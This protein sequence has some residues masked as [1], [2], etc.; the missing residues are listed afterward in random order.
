MASSSD[1]RE[2]LDLPRGSPT[3]R[4]PPAKKFKAD[5]KKPDGMQRELYSLLGENT[6]PIA[7]IENKFKDRPNWRQKVTPWV[8]APF[9][10]SNDGDDDLVL[11]HWVR[12]AA[13]DIN[14]EYQFC[15]YNTQIDVP[16][17][18]KEDYDAAFQDSSWSFEE[19]KYLFD[20]C[21][22]Y[23]LRWV[24]IHDR[25]AF[26]RNNSND[27]EPDQDVEMEEANAEDK[28]D[29]NSAEPQTAD[30]DSENEKKDNESQSERE[31]N[32]QS[33][34]S[35]GSAKP[36]ESES[37]T[38][39][40]K[41][42]SDENGKVAAKEED[43]SDGRSLEDLKARFYDVY[44]ALFKARQER[45]ETL[46][47][48]EEDLWKQMK[49]SKDNEK[50]R[51]AHLEK[52][53][54]RSPAEVAEEEAL[55]IESRKLEAAAERMLAERKEI[56][57]LLDVPRPTG[58]VSQYLSSQGLAQLTN[59]LLS[60][61]ARK[62]K[63]STPT[64]TTATATASTSA[65]SSAATTAN[66]TAAAAASTKSQT[67]A[68]KKGSGATASSTVQAAIQH[69]LSAR[70]ETAYGISYHD[71]L[72]PGVYM[73]SSKITSYKPSVQAKVTAAL[74]ELGLPPR[75][76]MPTAKVCAKFESLQHS[77]GVLLE[78]KRQA[79]KLEAE[80]K[81]ARGNAS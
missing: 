8:W 2:M 21:R 45:G 32:G 13:P 76:V 47:P 71:K 49:Y 52:L 70:E 80:L 69:K 1:V 36:E 60:E 57:R 56:L 31:S 35:E 42:S 43:G 55:V 51:K 75:P 14:E 41:E 11:H 16:Q 79:D 39:V 61:K 50:K 22:E 62:K 26:E 59:T 3:P 38:A 40:K 65:S 9:K 6:P 24:V 66:S 4:P 18:T 58:S 48:S 54:K 73:R 46:T 25:Y 78:A 5:N 34:Q 81:V 27:S 53:L 67:K 12:G 15:R 63:E 17:I 20:L 68:E 72:S 74:S 77:I 10:R 37:S 19:T 28:E 64:P 29:S 33:D 23:D 44:R 30:K 7:V